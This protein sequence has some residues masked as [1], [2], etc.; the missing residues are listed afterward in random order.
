MTHPL[1]LPM[2]IQMSIPIVILFIMA[3]RRV[4]AVKKAGSPSAL[5]KAGGFSTSLVNMGDN[6]KNQFELP[7]L[8]YGVCLLVILEGQAS[9]TI[10]ISAWVFVIFRIFHSI[11]HCTNNKIF[12]NRFGTFLISALALTVILI[13]AFVQLLNTGA[14]S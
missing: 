4:L 11:V 2:L 13:S 7:V 14:T 5:R 10:V 3:P 8:F 9:K 6:L 12:P 1:A